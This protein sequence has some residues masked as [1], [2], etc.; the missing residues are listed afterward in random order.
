MT[1]G[2]GGRSGGLGTGGLNHK[3]LMAMSRV[4]AATSVALFVLRALYNDS[5]AS[6]AGDGRSDATGAEQDEVRHILEVFS[7]LEEQ[8]VVHILRA[9]KGMVFPAGEWLA[10]SVCS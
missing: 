3:H 9:L 7:N 10:S 1:P 5:H 8:V 4:V 6:C 2:V